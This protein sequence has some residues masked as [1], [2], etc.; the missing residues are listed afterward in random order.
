[1]D[2]S[3]RATSADILDIV[4]Q[5]PGETKRREVSWTHTKRRWCWTHQLVQR[6]KSREV[7]LGLRAGL[8]FFQLFPNGGAMDIVTVLHSIWN[9]NIA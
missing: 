8:L 4:A 1:M 5:S 9:S 7:E 3:A 6:D 2:R